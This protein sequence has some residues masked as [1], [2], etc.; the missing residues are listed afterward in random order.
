[1]TLQEIKDALENGKKVYWANKSYS[2]IK[3][4]FK[5]S[6]NETVVQ[7]LISCNLN[8]FCIGL[9]HTNGVTLN[10]NENQFF[11]ENE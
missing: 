6:N 9:T 7:Y 3:D 1:M 5:G 4:E 2:V 11:C 8:S 10:G